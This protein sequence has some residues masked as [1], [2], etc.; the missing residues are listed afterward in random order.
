MVEK[1]ASPDAVNGARGA[2]RKLVFSPYGRWD[3]VGVP[4]DVSDYLDQRLQSLRLDESRDWDHGA[5]CLT[6]ERAMGPY[7]QWV[8]AC[9]PSAIAWHTAHGRAEMAAQQFAGR[10]IQRVSDD[11]ARSK[12]R[13]DQ[14]FAGSRTYVHRRHCRERPNLL[15]CNSGS[16]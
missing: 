2:Q 1:Q 8:V 9:N 12:L 14:F 13:E 16:G 11:D 10:R 7:D 15:L 3:H 5:R 6:V 4:S